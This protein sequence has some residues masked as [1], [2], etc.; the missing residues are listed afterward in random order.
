ME[1]STWP[2]TCPL[3]GLRLPVRGVDGCGWLTAG[4][5]RWLEDLRGKNQGRTGREGTGMERVEVA[6][7][8]IAC[9]RAVRDFLGD[10]PEGA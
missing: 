5:R 10:L 4:G 1:K 9:E 3:I 2:S 7:L 8:Q 6:G